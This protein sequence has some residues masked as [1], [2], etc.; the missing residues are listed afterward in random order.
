MIHKFF[1]ASKTLQH[2]SRKFGFRQL[3]LFQGGLCSA[4]QQCIDRNQ[5]K[6]IIAAEFFI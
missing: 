3:I 5:I 1:S 2:R 4:L 6:Q